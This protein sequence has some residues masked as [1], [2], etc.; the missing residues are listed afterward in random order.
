M[1]AMFIFG[2]FRRGQSRTEQQKQANGGKAANEEEEGEH[3]LW[4]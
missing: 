2:R 3:K 4:G 1:E